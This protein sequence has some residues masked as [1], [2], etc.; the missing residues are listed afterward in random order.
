MD[1][2]LRAAATYAAVWLI[3]RVAGKRSLAEITTFD[4]VLLLII[5]EAVQAALLAKDNSMTNSFLV[6]VTMVGIDIAASLWKQ[7]SKAADR[8]IDG[9][10]L[11]ILRD[12]VPLKERMDRER[13]DESDILAAAR[14]LHGLERLEQIKYAV[15]E[16]NGGISVVPVREAPGQDRVTL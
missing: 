16:R 5:S 4:F 7:R 2:V 15:L 13:V 3:L 6:V 10:P 11:V 14:L 1:T 12:G 9:T 8:W